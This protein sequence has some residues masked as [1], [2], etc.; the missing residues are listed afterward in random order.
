MIILV[1][2]PAGVGKTTVARKLMTY[3][4]RAVAIDGENACTVHPAGRHGDGSADYRSRTI[5]H[6]VAFHVE[7]GWDDFV[8][9]GHWRAPAELRQLRALLNQVDE[10]IHSYRLTCAEPAMRRRLNA[11]RAEDVEH[12]LR[13]FREE[14]AALDEAS[15]GA[16]MGFP[17]DGSA[18]AP[19]QVAEAIWQNL[20]EEGVLSPYSSAWAEAFATERGRIGGALGGLARGIH[21]VGST[22]VPGL[23]AKPIL[24]IMVAIPGLDD[25]LLCIAPLRTLGYAFVDHAQNTDRRFFRKGFPRTHHLHVVEDGGRTLADHVDFR[26]ALRTR[27]ELREK[28]GRLKADLAQ[29]F[30][31]DRARYTSSK[32]AFIDQALR[33]YRGLPLHP[34]P[35]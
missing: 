1:N 31:R 5:Q 6:L 8:I 11:Q 34:L 3:F 2:G 16:D 15:R 13:H 9:T 25:A 22:S 17:V 12:A 18:L 14:D 20:R 28:Y 23:A 21:H 35:E 26:D 4:D 24:D 27:P 32:S 29:R 30:T 19:V 7:N 10:E 33:D